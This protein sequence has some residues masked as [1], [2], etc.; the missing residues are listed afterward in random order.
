[1]VPVLSKIM[2]STSP[3]ASTAFPDMAMTL[4]RV[5]RSIPAIPIADSRPPIV[6]G[7]KQT[8]K[9]IRVE[10]VSGTCTNKA[11][12]YSVTITI[13]KIMV[14]L[15]SKVFKAISFGVF[16]RDQE[17]AAAVLNSAAPDRPG[18]SVIHAFIV[19]A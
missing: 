19:Q 7:I 10:T 18:Q 11:I 8:V 2:V 5:T 17:D 1:M 14:K 3:L 9:A 4:N 16:L 12:G 6:V 15:T 13:I